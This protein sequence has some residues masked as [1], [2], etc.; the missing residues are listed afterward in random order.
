MICWK[1][2]IEKIFKLYSYINKTLVDG[3]ISMRENLLLRFFKIA[4]DRFI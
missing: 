4:N 3:V 1:T 2:L